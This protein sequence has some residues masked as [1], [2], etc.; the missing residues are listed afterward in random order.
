[1]RRILNL[2]SGVPQ[3]VSMPNYDF[4]AL[5]PIDFEI[6]VRDLLQQERKIRLE[7]F[8]PGKDSGI[9]FRYCRT[10][11]RKLIVQCKHYAQS[12]FSALYSEMKAELGKVKRLNP[13]SYVLATSLPL[14]ERQK[15]KLEALLAPFVQRPGDIYG[16]ED[17]NNLLGQ[18]EN[19]ERR[20][21]KLWMSSVPALAG[22]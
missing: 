11:H 18:F 9:D 13:R 22:C 2:A 8:K 19:I 20:T 12:S 6:L 17:I 4:T 14:N 1:M 3:N 7:S 10:R 5:S 21:F 15:A 16:K